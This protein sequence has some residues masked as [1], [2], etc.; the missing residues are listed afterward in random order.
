MEGRDRGLRSHVCAPGGWG[1]A[2][3][4]WGPDGG[5]GDSGVQPGRA[6]A[7]VQGSRAPLPPPPPECTWKMAGWK[8]DMR[9]MACRSRPVASNT[10]LGSCFPCPPWLQ[11]GSQRA[12]GQAGC[13]GQ[14]LPALRRQGQGAQQVRQLVSAAGGASR[15]GWHD[16][17]WLV[18]YPSCH[19]FV[20]SPLMAGRKGCKNCSR[21]LQVAA[22]PPVQ[23]RPTCML[24]GRA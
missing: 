21:V 12:G 22:Q 1:L 7:P 16:S 14:G 4:G 2:G 9:Q 11:P 20:C 6:C 3:W 5:C 17:C 23:P 13:A 10:P 15:R 24:A 8:R 18:R 19:R